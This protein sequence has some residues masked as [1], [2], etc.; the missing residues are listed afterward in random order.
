MSPEAQDELNENA[1]VEASCESADESQTEPAAED[2]VAVLTRERDGA[3]DQ[4]VRL[5]AEFD[6]F[7]KRTARETERIRK[8]AAAS[9]VTDLL[10]V[11]DNLGRALETIGC[12]SDL[13][14]GSAQ[15]GMISGVRMVAEQFASVLISHGVEP[16]PAQGES[17]D[18]NIHEAIARVVSG[19]IPSGH[20][21][22]EY[23]K[24]Y[25]MG[26]FVLRASKVV[27]SMGPEAEPMPNTGDLEPEAPETD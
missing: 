27:V 9:L 20:I 26:D 12:P 7:R 18:P 13:V 15:E 25:R 1:E 4:Y 5:R 8:M 10:P 17:F 23:L 3:L 11:L 24:G 16:I 22:Q 21:V 6:N 14:A 2:P 19:D